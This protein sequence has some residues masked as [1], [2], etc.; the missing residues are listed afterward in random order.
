MSK[1]VSIPPYF[2]CP[3]SQRIMEDPVIWVDG[4]T[5]ERREIERWLAS[6]SSN[7]TYVEAL[8][9]NTLISNHAIKTGIEMFR[10]ENARANLE[11][12]VAVPSRFICPLSRRI[13]KEPVLCSD[14]NTYEKKEIERWF[15]LSDKYPT[16]H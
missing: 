12:T 10:K 16:R 13:M 7:R 8:P 5:Y 9:S 1:A 14:G 3:I 6:N 11:E 4:N 2:I 15:V